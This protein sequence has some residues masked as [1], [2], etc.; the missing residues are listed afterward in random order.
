[1]LPLPTPVDL[2]NLLYGCAPLPTP[3]TIGQ[4]QIDSQP[5]RRVQLQSTKYT[6]SPIS[7]TDC[8]QKAAPVVNTWTIFYFWET[9]HLLIPPFKDLWLIQVFNGKY[10]ANK[11]KR[12]VNKFTYSI[13]GKHRMIYNI[14]QTTAMNELPQ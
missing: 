4:T 7:A 5:Q 1:M 8:R 10:N 12:T 3:L 2:A 9:M 6:P 13:I 14:K 11:K